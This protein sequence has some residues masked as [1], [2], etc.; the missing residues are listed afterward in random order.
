MGVKKVSFFAF[1][2]AFLFL[3]AACLAGYPRVLL[4]TSVGDITMELY[5]DKA[6][7]TV[8]N[9][10]QYVR[11]DFYTDLIFH[12]VE[13]PFVIQSGGYYLD[14]HVIYRQITNAPI[15][16]ES[17]N[18]LSNL[19]GTVAMARTNDPNSATSQFYINL[20][21]NNSLDK[22]YAADKYGYCVFAKIISG[23][24]VVNNIALTPVIDINYVYP[25]L[26]HFPAT[27]IIINNSEL[28]T[29]GY[30][31]PGDIG[32]DGIVN[33]RDFA[34]L[35]ANWKKTGNNLWGDLNQNNAVDANDVHLFHQGWLTKTA[36]YKPIEQDL[37]NDG[38]VNFEDF[39]L[40]SRNWQRPGRRLTGNF[41]QD[42]YVDQLDLMF[43]AEKWLA[44]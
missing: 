28:L 23:M 43:F 31:L 33:F 1:L 38:I 3:Q 13:N 42:I 19:R 18:N 21:D 11:T 40:F 39:A 9:F 26:T 36:W 20:A 32:N 30:W 37:N 27:P 24:D 14:G 2:M 17:Y 25:D 44:H 6:P 8:E 10:L 12:R 16:N 34:Y 15:I 7:I 35:A 22:K 29:P 5:N 4:K 41:N